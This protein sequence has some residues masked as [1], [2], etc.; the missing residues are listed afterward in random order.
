MKCGGTGRRKTAGTL[1]FSLT[2]LEP[3]KEIGYPCE[4]HDYAYDCEGT[5]KNAI[6]S[7]GDKPQN[8]TC[9][10]KKLPTKCFIHIV[11]TGLYLNVNLLWIV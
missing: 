5:A 2:S 8:K 6:K 7:L 10:Y 1:G 4:K 11:V 9:G 3:D